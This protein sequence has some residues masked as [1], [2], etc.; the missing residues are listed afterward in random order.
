MLKTYIFLLFHIQNPP[1]PNQ[2]VFISANRHFDSP[3]FFIWLWYLLEAQ[4]WQL[5]KGKSPDCQANGLCRVGNGCLVHTDLEGDLSGEEG[6]TSCHKNAVFLQLNCTSFPAHCVFA[7][8]IPNLSHYPHRIESHTEHSNR[9]IRT[10]QM[11]INY[12]NIFCLH[13]YC[14]H[15]KKLPQSTRCRA[16]N[17]LLQV[18]LSCSDMSWAQVTSYWARYPT[19]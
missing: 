8:G 19:G 4:N 17:H 3:V 9:G 13:F 11:C 14:C 10:T 15:S 7:A 18:H 5:Q 12:C 2:T 1:H 6:W 16:E